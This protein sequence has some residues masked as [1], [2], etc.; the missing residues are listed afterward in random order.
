MISQRMNHCIIE[1]DSKILVDACNGGLG[2]AYFGTFV[3][4]CIQL[5]KHINPVLVRFVYR[6]AN[7]VAQLQ[8]PPIL[9]QA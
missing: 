2:E 6:S 5:W 9:C 7:G 8:R 1:S 4:D 3:K